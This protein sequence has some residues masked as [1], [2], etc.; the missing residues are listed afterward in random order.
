M[1]PPAVPLGERNTKPS[2]LFECKLSPWRKNQSLEDLLAAGTKSRASLASSSLS[3]ST[4]RG[5][6][7]FIAGS[8]SNLGSSRL[9]R[10]QQK[11]STPV[12][13][14]ELARTEKKQ[15]NPL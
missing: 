2:H 10:S 4:Q 6:L 12:L 1:P 11:T 5:G 9:T 7:S 14:I 8:T 15:D 3:A 13:W